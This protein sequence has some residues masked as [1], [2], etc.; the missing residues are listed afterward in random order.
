MAN[1]HAESPVQKRKSCHAGQ[2]RPLSKT[3]VYE[4]SAQAGRKYRYS[5]QRIPGLIDKHSAVAFQVNYPAM[6]LQLQ[7]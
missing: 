6:L 5:V 4:N 2:K 1:Q 3:S 7:N